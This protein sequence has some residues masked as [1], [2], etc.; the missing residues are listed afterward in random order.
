VSPAGVE[1]STVHTLMP[2][3]IL[4]HSPLV[5][6]LT[7]MLVADELRQ[8]GVNA[9]APSLAAGGAGCRPYWQDHATAV[10]RALES[11]PVDQPLVLVGHSGAGPLLPAVGEAAGRPIAA[12]VFVDADIPQDGAS[13]LDLAG[14]PESAERVRRQASDGFL[15]N[16]WENEE[17]LRAVGIEDAELRRRF[18]AEVSKV[19]LAIYEEPLPVFAGWPDAPCGYLS[20]TRSSRFYPQSIGRAK[21]EGWAYGEVD[22][23]HFHMLVDPPAVADVLLELTARME[24]G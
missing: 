5:G 22:G 7:W 10:A 19:P 21:R 4:I 13:R 9:I 23:G 8:R 12:Y 17:V 20:F 1:F 14:S 2:T 3:F 6:L 15:P 18:L 16:L 24:A 11:V